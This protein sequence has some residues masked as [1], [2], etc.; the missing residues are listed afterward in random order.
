MFL[1]G[2][3][4]EYEPISSKVVGILTLPSSSIRYL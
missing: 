1:Q 4:G 2:G 3:K